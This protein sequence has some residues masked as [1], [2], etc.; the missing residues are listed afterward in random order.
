MET[1]REGLVLVVDDDRNA[2][3]ILYRM[4]QKEGF[5]VLRAHGGPQAIEIATAQPVDVIL[6]DVMMPQMD[7]FQ[8]CAVLRGQERTRDIPVILLTAKDDMETRARGMKLAVSEYL[9]K[10]VNKLE[11]LPRVQAQVRARELE[12]R[13]SETAAA[14]AELVEK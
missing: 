9:T 7:G 8:V 13:L 10:P 6:L 5:E 4:L 11:L 14:V 12:R 3:E 2:V 1:K